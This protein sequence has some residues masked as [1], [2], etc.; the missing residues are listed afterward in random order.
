MWRWLLIATVLLLLAV[1][2]FAQ[3]DDDPLPEAVEMEEGDAT[4]EPEP[5]EVTPEPTPPPTATE[6]PTPLPATATATLIS[7]ADLWLTQTAV[8]AAMRGSG[9]QII[10]IP[11]P[12]A[13]P[14]TPAPEPPIV[15]T[16]VVA[17]YYS[18]RTRELSVQTRIRAGENV[19]FRAAGF[20]P[21]ALV[22]IDIV[23]DPN[24]LMVPSRELV[25]ERCEINGL[26]RTLSFDRPGLYTLRVRG[27]GYATE[28][29]QATAIFELY[30]T[31]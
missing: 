10:T 11:Q 19:P 29:A 22:Q 24:S 6:T 26:V 8:I 12:P 28:N 3:D 20:R 31:R 30:T 16:T 2:V 13:P 5:T 27:P 4:P 15:V 23:E 7:D 18:C 14:R 25:N 1:P 21:G 17:E 9:I